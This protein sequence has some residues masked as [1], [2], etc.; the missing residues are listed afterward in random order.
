MFVPESQLET[1]VVDLVT[2]TKTMHACWADPEALASAL[3][4]EVRYTSLGGNWEGASHD[5]VV[6]ID[7]ARGTAARQRFTWYHELTHALIRRND[8]LY[9][10]LDE[11]YQ[12]EAEFTRIRERLSDIG[13][14]EFLLPRDH[15]RTVLAQHGYSIICL[16]ALSDS[17]GAS[18]TAVCVQIARCS[19]HRCIAVVCQ[20]HHVHALRQTL[21]TVPATHPVLRVAVSMP[22]PRMEYPVAR[23]T[24]IPAGHLL[25]DAYQSE[26]G[27]VVR[28]EATIPFK[29]GK[30][31]IVPC[32]AVR[33]G[34]QVFSIFY[35][36][37]PQ[38]QAPGQ[39]T[40]F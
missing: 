1:M 15:I 34:E 23:G 19:P 26:A 40:L 30:E 22:S 13:A 7:P 31:W 33:L 36:D 12:R 11:Q 14:A 20:S 28:G 27:R 38:K 29:S 16:E 10:I 4:L 2:V 32:E 39:M 18:L 17:S 35:R 9:A 24:I 8:E 3:G 25:V 6:V 21:L 37:T 5:R